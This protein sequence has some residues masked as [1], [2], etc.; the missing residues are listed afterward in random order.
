VGADDGMAQLRAPGLQKDEL[1]KLLL[2]IPL[3]HL[4]GMAIHHKLVLKDGDLPGKAF[5]IL[6]SRSYAAVASASTLDTRSSGSLSARVAQPSTS[7]TRKAALSYA[8]VAFRAEVS[9]TSTAASQAAFAA[10]IASCAWV[11]STSSVGTS[12]L[13]C[14]CS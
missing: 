10:A 8:A 14:T 13:P 11:T 7:L 3:R 12:V 9:A 2:V 6:A 1:L 5:G 4:L